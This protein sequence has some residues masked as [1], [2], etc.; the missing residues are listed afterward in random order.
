MDEWLIRALMERLNDV[1]EVTVAAMQGKHKELPTGD[2][3]EDER[4]LPEPE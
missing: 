4:D 1:R 3:G 2:R